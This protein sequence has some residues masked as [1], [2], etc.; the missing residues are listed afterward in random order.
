MG[1]I[2]VRTNNQP[3][4]II[5]AYALT[6]D[7]RKEFDYLNWDKIDAGEDSA[8]FF[9]YRGELYDLGEFMA[10]NA[11]PA[12]S[13]LPAHLSKWDGH[14]ADSYFSATVVRYVNDGEQ[15]IVGYVTS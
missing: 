10:G 15:V 13:G 5:D 8:S 7:E 12:D 9:R 6:A 11:V 2:K 1:D 4:D 14:H 3:R